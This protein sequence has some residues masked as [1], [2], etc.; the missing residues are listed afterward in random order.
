LAVNSEAKYLSEKVTELFDQVSCHL[1]EDDE[2]FKVKKPGNST[3][4][5]FRYID[6]IIPLLLSRI[7][8]HQKSE[9]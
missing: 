7:D 1:E 3:E 4:D 8:E 9:K 6:E 5:K 2:I